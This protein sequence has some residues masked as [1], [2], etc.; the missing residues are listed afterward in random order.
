MDISRILQS[1]TTSIDGGQA[2]A[3]RVDYNF[4]I[5]IGPESLNVIPI[6]GGYSMLILGRPLLHRV[7]PSR[8]KAIPRNNMECGGVAYFFMMSVVLAGTVVVMLLESGR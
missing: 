8:T 5:T 3:V 2:W 1:F 4:V 7:A 6:S